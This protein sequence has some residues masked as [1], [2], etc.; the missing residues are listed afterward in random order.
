MKAK[1]QKKLKKRHELRLEKQCNEVMA[2]NNIDVIRKAMDSLVSI[3]ENGEIT[4][5]ETNKTLLRECFSRFLT[6]LKPITSKWTIIDINIVGKIGNVVSNKTEIMSFL[7][8]YESLQLKYQKKEVIVAIK[9]IYNNF[10]EYQFARNQSDV[11]F[12][13]GLYKKFQQNVEQKSEKVNELLN[14][15]RQAIQQK[16]FKLAKELYEQLQA[17]G[18][19]ENKLKFTVLNNCIVAK[20]DQQDFA[21]VLKLFHINIKTLRCDMPLKNGTLVS[22]ATTAVIIP[23]IQGIWRTDKDK[24]IYLWKYLIDLGMPCQAD[25]SYNHALIISIASKTMD[26][27]FI[28]VLL[29]SNVVDIN[30]IIT[31][32]TDITCKVI[33]TPFSVAV[34]KLN[35]ELLSLLL[36]YG[37]DPYLAVNEARLIMQLQHKPGIKLVIS[38]GLTENL[39]LEEEQQKYLIRLDEFIE[40]FFLAKLVKQ[41]AATQVRQTTLSTELQN[42]KEILSDDG[43]FFLQEENTFVSETPPIARDLILNQYIKYKQDAQ[44]NTALP[45]RKILEHKF[46]ALL[47]NWIQS[48]NTSYLDLLNTLLEENPQLN[49]YSATCLL[50][51]NIPIN[52][53]N[54]TFSDNPKLLHQF[55]TLKKKLNNTTKITSENLRLKDDVYEVHG[56]FTNKIFIQISQKII[57][58]LPKDYKAK[59]LNQ[60]PTIQFIKTNSKGIS[61]IKSYAGCYK[62][63]IS[64]TNENLYS[65]QRYLDKEG[66]ILIV[67][68]NLG[69]HGNT[70]YK[71][72][73]T[74]TYSDFKEAIYITN[75]DSASVISHHDNVYQGTSVLTDSIAHTTE[76]DM[77]GE[78]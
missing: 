41:D 51:R 13:E 8:N 68:D 57:E 18:F 60:L 59:I 72:N 26:L 17:W 70:P 58:E 5:T 39:S 4:V 69:D 74:T 48:N 25:V 62:L 31:S 75:I 24:A 21:K 47:L 71:G 7:N 12:K 55:Y 9:E 42:K 49:T 46:D 22:M 43:A 54:V 65:T 64:Q 34:G 67:F 50:H 40:S 56:N 37:A 30:T 11:R 15:F 32:K 14:I 29:E 53:V 63:K 1:L 76:I 6:M 38:S 44:H 20:F 77:L 66:N 33:K 23:Y 52:V 35:F 27:S 36:E 2:S 16:S 45:T 19:L 28:K 3:Y 78:Y 61:G 73:I 10:L